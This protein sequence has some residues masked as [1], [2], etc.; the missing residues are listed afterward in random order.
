MNSALQSALL[1]DQQ[2]AARRRLRRHLPSGTTP[3]IYIYIYI[4]VY[5]IDKTN[6]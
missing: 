3:Y 1:G 6:K 5:I 4:Y 2:L